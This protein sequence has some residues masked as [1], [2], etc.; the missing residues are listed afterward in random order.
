MRTILIIL[1]I[2]VFSFSCKNPPP[3]NKASQIQQETAVADKPSDSTSFYYQIDTFLLDPS[4]SDKTPDTAFVYPPSFKNPDDPHDGGCI[5]NN[6]E[7]T[8]RFSD[9]FPPF[10]YEQAISAGVYNIGDI[11]SDG[12]SEL[13]V[14]PGWFQSCW[15]AMVLYTFKGDHWEI[16]G[17]AR[18]YLCDDEEIAKRV[19]K[20]NQNVL[21]IT[22]DDMEDGD[23]VQKKKRISL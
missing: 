22:W 19:K 15:G 1:V 16:F 17:T 21:E 4:N 6:C 20:I 11:N 9:N 3:D 23:R 8:V 13:M 7:V 14:C 10:V 5:N 12:I 2:A 18:G